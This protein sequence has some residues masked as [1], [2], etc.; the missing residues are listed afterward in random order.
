MPCGQPRQNRVWP[1][2]SDNLPPRDT[3]SRRAVIRGAVIFQS[4][5]G[6]TTGGASAP[7]RAT[8]GAGPGPWEAAGSRARLSVPSGWQVTCSRG[9]VPVTGP[10][11]T[12]ALGS[13]PPTGKR[14]LGQPGLVSTAVTEPA[15]TPGSRGQG[16]GQYPRR[17]SGTPQGAECTVLGPWPQSYGVNPPECHQAT[18]H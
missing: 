13:V 7:P 5:D 9:Q 12:S 2:V 3:G 15:T 11:Q 4:A 17:G 8:E 1:L 14:R 6:E 10:D 18:R 16:C